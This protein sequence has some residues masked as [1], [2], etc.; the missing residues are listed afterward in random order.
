LVRKGPGRVTSS[1]AGE[2]IEGF[3][4]KLEQEFGKR[5]PGYEKAIYPFAFSFYK[6]KEEWKLNGLAMGEGAAD[7]LKASNVTEPVK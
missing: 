3:Q 5:I 1:E 2:P 6:P 7:D 4:T